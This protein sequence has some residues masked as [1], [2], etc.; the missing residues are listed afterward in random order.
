[1]AFEIKETI[2]RIAHYTRSANNTIIYLEKFYDV[3]D[4]VYNVIGEMEYNF[5]ATDLVELTRIITLIRETLTQY[6]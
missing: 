6:T 5:D 1:M 4:N 2:K 3:E